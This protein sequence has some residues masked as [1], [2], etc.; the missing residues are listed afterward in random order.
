MTKINA[1]NTV[2]QK[3][4]ASVPFVSFN[5][6]EA[7]LNRKLINLGNNISPFDLPQD[8]VL[9]L[10]QN[11]GELTRNY[12]DPTNSEL[13]DE[14]SKQ[15]SYRPE[16]ILV[17]AGIDSLLC[18]IARTFTEPGAKAVTTYGTYPTFAYFVK[19]QGGELCYAAYRQDFH[20]DLDQLHKLTQ[21]HQP[22]LLYLVNPDNPTGMTISP[23][24]LQSFLEA[25]PRHT[26]VIIDEAYFDF[27]EP[28][29][30]LQA[31]YTPENVLRLRTFS[32]GYGLAG[33]RIGYCLGS[34]KLL[35]EMNKVRIQFEVNH[36]AQWMALQLLKR[37]DWHKA[38]CDKTTAQLTQLQKKARSL[39]ITALPSFTNFLCL[40]FGTEVQAKKIQHL[41]LEKYGIF[42]RKPEAAPLASLIRFSVGKPPEMQY[43]LESLSEVIEHNDLM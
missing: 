9:K 36:L 8:L 34:P 3:L 21:L 27:L 33:L 22:S 12:G 1:G 13:R 2:V 40:H 29:Q 14:L 28:S 41:L 24:Q 20:L 42:T 10:T 7:R 23:A 17:S 37:S 26:I 25:L 43:L 39:N 6:M 18:L 19:S 30:R 32:K 35:K 15:L 4:K 16:E 31:L 5:E 11:L 38:C